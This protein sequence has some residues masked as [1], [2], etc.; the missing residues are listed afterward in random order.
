MDDIGISEGFRSSL[1][2]IKWLQGCSREFQMVS[3]EF[4]G[5]LTGVSHDFSSGILRSSMRFQRRS[6]VLHVRARSFQGLSRTYKGDLKSFQLVIGHAS[7][8]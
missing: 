6:G 8:G 3:R 5:S 2:A 7:S 4:Q 1:S